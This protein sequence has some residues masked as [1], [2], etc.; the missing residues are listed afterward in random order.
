MVSFVLSCM[1]GTRR[2]QSVR[3]G[4]LRDSRAPGAEMV[5][6]Q[7]EEGVRVTEG[8]G[9]TGVTGH[10]SLPGGRTGLGQV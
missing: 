4:R 6:G 10:L 3:K 5:S 1:V 7:L 2:I 9:E 8:E